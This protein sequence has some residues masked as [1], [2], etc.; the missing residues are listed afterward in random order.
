[1]KNTVT[2][3]DYKGGK[4]LLKVKLKDNEVFINKPG[5]IGGK[6][7]IDKNTIASYEVIDAESQTS[8]TSAVAR[9][10]VGAALLGPIGIAAALSA[11]KKGLHTIAIQF[12]DG[13]SSMLAVDKEIYKNITQILFGIS[14]IENN[15]V[16]SDN[17]SN[18]TKNF[19]AASEIA[20]FKELFDAGAI[21]Q[22]EY[23]AK[24][25]QLLNL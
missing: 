9:G 6:I 25:K 18:D 7:P 23:E 14:Q 19:D 13:K 16:A 24:K 20:K 3:G 1:M 22:D 5:F 11:K 4:V 2:S 21:T 12:K 15:S 10:Y 8:A 17:S